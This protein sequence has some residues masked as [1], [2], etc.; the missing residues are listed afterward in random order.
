MTEHISRQEYQSLQAQPKRKNKF[1]AKRVLHDGI[2]FDSKAERNY[3]ADLKLRER[4]GEVTDVDR[5][6]PYD[7]IVNGILIA[8]YVADV[9]YFDRILCRRRVVDVKGAPL[10]REFRIKQKLIKSI[11]GIDV[12]VVRMK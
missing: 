8:R 3:Y 11:F 4:A 10:T 12:E 5:Q 7:L 2:L 6:R 9:V 1:N